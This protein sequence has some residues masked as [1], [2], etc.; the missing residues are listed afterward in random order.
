VQFT[1]IGAPG[2]SA[3][4][5]TGAISMRPPARSNRCRRYSRYSGIVTTGAV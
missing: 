4:D 5:I 2:R 1:T 3:S